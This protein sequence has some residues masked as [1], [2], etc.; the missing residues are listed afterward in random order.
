[1]TRNPILNAVVAAIYIV[2]VGILLFYGSQAL[3]PVNSVLAPIAIISLFTLSAAVMGYVFLSEP[4]ALY[5]NDKKGEALGLFTRTV[6][7]F[8]AITLI[9]FIILVIA[10]R[11]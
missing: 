1:M 3:G 11:G 2:V 8:A 7:Y 10:S 6:I 9:V 4:I 5:F